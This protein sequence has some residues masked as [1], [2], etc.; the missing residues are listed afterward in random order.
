MRFKDYQERDTLIAA[1]F[2]A[3]DRVVSIANA[4]ECDLLVVAGD[5][6]DRVAVKKVDVHRV[7]VSLGA[8]AGRAVLVLPGNHDYVTTDSTLWRDFRDAASDHIYVLAEPKPHD[9]RDT[10]LDAIIYPAPCDAKHS[11][12]NRIGWVADAVSRPSADSTGERQLRHIGIAHG[13]IEGVSP[14]FGGKYFP[15][16]RAELGAAGVDLWL[17]GHSHITWPAVPDARSTVLNPGTPEPDG[18]DCDHEGRAFLIELPGDRVGSAGG[19]PDAAAGHHTAGTHGTRGETDAKNRPDPL[20]ESAAERKP[21][22]HTAPRAQHVSDPR[23]E[24]VSTGA[25]RFRHETLEIRT[26]DDPPALLAKL[27]GD[28]LSSTVLRLRARGRVDEDELE[29][30]RDMAATLREQVLELDLRTDELEE[31]IGRDRILRTYSEQSF[32][33]RLLLSFLEDNDSAALEEAWELL[34][35][36][37]Q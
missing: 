23:I 35:E 11:E 24:V 34:E 37:R 33:A 13:S 3:V 32:A 25:C 5:L 20:S 31:A 4:R 2:E 8:F 17:T 12:S 18:F 1:R 29:A 36:S 28:D 14:D 10:D 30:F 16:T 7:A 22:P 9:L 21:A 27:S 15:M 6:F 26:A 19:G